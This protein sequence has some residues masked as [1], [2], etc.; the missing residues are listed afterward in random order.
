ML[1][2]KPKPGDNAEKIGQK[3]TISQKGG[4]T[5]ITEA[6]LDSDNDG[7]KDWEE[8]LW[9]TDPNNP[10]TDG[11]GVKDGE[12]LK[13]GRDPLK[14]G[15]DDKLAQF[16][17]LPKEPE[18]TFSSP[19]N[20]TE[21]LARQLIVQYFS[22]KGKGETP[23]ISPDNL[24]K[25]ILSQSEGRTL[26]DEFSEKDLN[27]FIEPTKE[28]KK[29]YLN[30]L[31][32]ILENNFKNIKGNEFEILNESLAK[33][34]E[35]ELEKLVPYISAYQKTVSDLQNL[36]VPENKN[37]ISLH[38]LLMNIMNNLEKSVAAMK[39]V[40]QDQLKMVLGMNWYLDEAV[41]WKKFEE[42]FRILAVKDG[43]VFG[44]NEGGAFIVK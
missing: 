22:Q 42:D 11:D 41:R 26:K 21:E 16:Q 3:E 35:E 24:A 34:K 1:F 28:N 18:P 8:K 37:Y 23:A 9:G 20:L 29:I 31:G 33:G 13:Q 15:P 7:L 2:K 43:I 4:L 10:D 39:L 19:K 5:Q 17:S 14:P 36:I 6:Q 25:D 30:R 27:K 32:E 40:F 12:E 38:L 44:K